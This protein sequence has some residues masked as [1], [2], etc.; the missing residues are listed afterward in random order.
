M[1]DVCRFPQGLRYCR[2]M[3]IMQALRHV[4]IDY[5]YNELISNIYDRATLGIGLHQNTE[6]TPAQIQQGDIISLKLLVM[7]LKDVFKNLE[8][9]DK[10]INIIGKRL[11]NLKFA[12]DIVI[13]TY[14]METIKELIEL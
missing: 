1:D 14:S 10:G 11:T 3:G 13:M 12:D 9:E 6:K 2:E 5:R 7:V 8:T 4:Q